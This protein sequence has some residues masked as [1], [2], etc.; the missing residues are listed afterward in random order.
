MWHVA[1]SEIAVNEY[2][3]YVRT[4]SGKLPLPSSGHRREDNINGSVVVEVL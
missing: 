4:A 3:M 1:R 2:N